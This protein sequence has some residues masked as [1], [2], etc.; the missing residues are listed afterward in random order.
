MAGSFGAYLAAKKLG[1][2]EEIC[3]HMGPS[4]RRAHNWT[5]AEILEGARGALSAS[6]L[7]ARNPNVYKAALKKG[8]LQKLFPGF[9]V[10][11]AKYSLSEVLAAARKYSSVKEF[12]AGDAK[13]YKSVLRLQRDGTGPK[14][15]WFKQ[16][17]AHMVPDTWNW[18]YEVFL[19]VTASY[20]TKMD[21]LECL[22]WGIYEKSLREGWIDRK[23]GR[24]PCA[25]N[26][27]PMLRPSRAKKR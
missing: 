12:R 5:R 16:A 4:R 17:T 24:A 7:L 11:A 8:L 10:G 23:Y 22:G 13:I 20:L 18:T 2:Y 1:V 27:R 26:P 21:L 25:K 6:D 19:E 15:E 3:A 9:E 14:R